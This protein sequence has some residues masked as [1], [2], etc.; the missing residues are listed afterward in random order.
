[1]VI[2]NNGPHIPPDILDKVLEP[3]F[4]T[5]PVGDGTGLG[6]SVSA[7]ILKEHDGNLE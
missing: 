3:F 2:A 7:T 1:L 4:T 6:L 5:K